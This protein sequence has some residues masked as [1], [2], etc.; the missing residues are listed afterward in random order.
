MDRRQFLS[1]ATVV[2]VIGMMRLAAPGLTA[3]Q[4]MVPALSQRLYQGTKDGK[5]YESIDGGETWQ[6]TANFGSHC[7]INRI[8]VQKN[9]DTDIKL[10]CA[11]YTFDLQSKDGRVWRTV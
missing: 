8:V 6:L 4:G 10:V 11:G 1:A 5:L 7:A 3:I 2:T 9:G